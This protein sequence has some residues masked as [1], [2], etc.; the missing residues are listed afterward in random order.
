[1]DKNVF[2]SLVVL[3]NPT[4]FPPHCNFEAPA[5]VED[6]WLHPKPIFTH[7]IFRDTEK[8]TLLICAHKAISNVLNYTKT[9]KLP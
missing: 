3:Y 6:F 2:T 8:R 5:L 1:M 7:C 4:S 9:Q